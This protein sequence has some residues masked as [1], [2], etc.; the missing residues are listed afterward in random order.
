MLKMFMLTGSYWS[1]IKMSAFSFRQ[2]VNI[3]NAGIKIKSSK[4]LIM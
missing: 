2:T 3:T 4:T 1:L